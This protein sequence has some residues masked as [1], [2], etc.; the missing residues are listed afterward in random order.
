MQ[1]GPGR[2]PQEQPFKHGICSCFENCTSCCCAFI[3]P[4][5]AMA[6]A[7]AD[8]DGSNCCFNYVSIFLCFTSCMLRSIVRDGYNIEGSCWGDICWPICL[9]CCSAAQLLNEVRER[10][11]VTK[12]FVQV[13]VQSIQR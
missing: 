5:C 4:A 6:Q 2:S 13:P 11:K 7:R 8:F 10:G 3:C 9:P 1:W 12:V